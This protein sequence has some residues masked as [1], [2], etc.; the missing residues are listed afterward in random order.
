MKNDRQTYPCAP[1][2]FSYVTIAFW[3]LAVA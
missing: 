1:A 3:L 2:E